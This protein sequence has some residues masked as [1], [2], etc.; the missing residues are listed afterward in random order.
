MVIHQPPHDRLGR[1]VQARLL[2]TRM[3]RWGDVA[4]GPVWAPHFLDDGETHPE[5]VGHA[6]W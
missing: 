5:H 6:A 1:R 4:S 3:G 2:T